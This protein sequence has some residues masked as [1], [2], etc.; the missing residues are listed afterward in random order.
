MSDVVR[1]DAISQLTRKCEA[2]DEN[3]IASFCHQCQ[4]WF[5]K[6]CQK[7]HAKM[8]LAQGHTYTSLAEKCDQVK[9]SVKKEIQNLQERTE[10][11]KSVAAQ[12]RKAN[13]NMEANQIQAK[14]TS[15]QLRAALHEDVDKYFD[16]IDERIDKLC[17]PVLD[18]VN[19]K[20][21]GNNDKLE[22]TEKLSSELNNMLKQDDITA[23][24]EAEKLVSDAQELVKSVDGNFDVV[25][26]IPRVG[27]ERNPNWSLEDAVTV[28]LYDVDNKPKV[29][30]YRTMAKK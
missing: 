20:T 27:L 29:R 14:Q 8:K 5:C 16:V 25:A 6:G 19:D 17:K 3:V 28:E 18:N 7:V 26:D 24:T 13:R 22:A 15:Q 11:L 21:S 23:L 10:E 9:D 30:Y 4:Q 1:I 2:C 12:N